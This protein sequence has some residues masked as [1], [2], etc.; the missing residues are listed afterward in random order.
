MRPLRQ[1]VLHQLAGHVR[2]RLVGPGNLVDLEVGRSVGCAHRS[3]I[4]GMLRRRAAG[5]RRRGARPQPDVA[6]PVDPRGRVGR[7]DDRRVGA[8]HQRR[9]SR[10]DAPGPSRAHSYTGVSRNRPVPAK[11]T[12]RAPSATA[13]VGATGSA[14]GGCSPPADAG[15]PHAGAD[16]LGRRIR[17]DAVGPPVRVAEGRDERRDVVVGLGHR[18]RQLVRLPSVAQ[19]G[20]SGHPRRRVVGPGELMACPDLELGGTPR[21]S[22][23]CS[24]HRGRPGRSGRPRSSARSRANRRRRRRPQPTA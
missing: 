14:A 19:V 7:H 23:R 13:G 5:E 6:V 22:C 17:G 4:A 20:R 12:G 16:E 2:R 21:R 18:D 10:V 24:T 3:P 9:S 15:D 11:R 8:D 1:R